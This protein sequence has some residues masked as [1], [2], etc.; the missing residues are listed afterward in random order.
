MTQ[1]H[2]LM[3]AE[4]NTSTLAVSPLPYH[5]VM[6]ATFMTHMAT[7]QVNLRTWVSRFPWPIFSICSQPVYPH[8]AN[9]VNQHF[10]YPPWHHCTEIV[11][12]VRSDSW[13]IWQVHIINNEGMRATDSIDD[14]ISNFSA[15][16]DVNSRL[17]FSVDVFNSAHNSTAT[18]RNMHNSLLSSLINLLQLQLTNSDI[19]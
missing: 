17:S 3:T 5:W 19:T 9:Q 12:D 2:T 11:S 10:S 4:S 14:C 16:S 1:W 15:V 7:F 8:M 13:F 18:N 6:V